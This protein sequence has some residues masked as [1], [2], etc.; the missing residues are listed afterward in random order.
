MARSGF[1]DIPPEMQ[2]Y[3]DKLMQFFN[4]YEN[5]G[6][7]V[8]NGIIPKK[9]KYLVPARSLLPTCGEYW[10]ALDTTAKNAWKSAGAE[11]N[12]N[13]WNLFVQ[14]TCYRLKYGIEGLATPSLLHQYKVGRMQIESPGSK[15]VIEQQH[16]IEWYFLKKIPGTKSQYYEQVVTEKLQLPLT[17]G[18]SYRSDLTAT[19]DSPIARFYV[20]ITSHYQGR[21]ITTQENIE[22]DLS[23]EWTRET[24]TVTEVLGV[25]RWYSLFIELRNVRGYIEFDNLESNHTGSNYARDFRC[26][27]I[28]T[29]LSNVYFQVSKA[30]ESIETSTGADFESVYPDD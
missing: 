26:N 10:Q 12:Y 8:K 24:K 13:G 2:A 11:T 6:T 1:I 7:R 23:S 30:W 21:N 16:P 29:P 9:K 5:A 25:A 18:L 17:I 20:I 28:D 4:R 3:Y 19:N 14:D 22:L 15:L 27:N